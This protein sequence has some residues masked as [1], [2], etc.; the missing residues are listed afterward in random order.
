MRICLFLL[1]I[2]LYA[3]PLLAAAP[4]TLE[5]PPPPPAVPRLLISEIQAN[6]IL[7]DDRAGEFV[8]IVNLARE[9]VRLADLSL[10]LPSGVRAVPVRPGAPLLHA[11]EVVLLT[12]LAT[13]AGEAAVKGMRLPNDSGR[14]EL[15][16]RQTRVDIAQWHKKAPWPTPRPGQALERTHPQA[17]GELGGTWRRSL[18]PLHGVERASP[19]R[20]E[21]PCPDVRGTALEGRCLP[22]HPSGQRPR[23][24]ISAILGFGR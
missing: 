24:R 15:F 18:S 12:P 3:L 22:P 4:T 13:Q 14:L 20:V 8:E 5:P 2:H 10:L 17:D 7:H 23:C 9:P 16:W 1:F 19:G 21:W 11:G 6:P